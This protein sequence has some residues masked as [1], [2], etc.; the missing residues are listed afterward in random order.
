MAGRVLAAMQFGVL[1]RVVLGAGAGARVFARLTLQAVLFEVLVCNRWRVLCCGGQ[2]WWF[3]STA[4]S[5]EVSAQIG[6]GVV[7]AALR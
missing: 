2:C 5:D 1:A 4:E 3:P 6:S 7:R